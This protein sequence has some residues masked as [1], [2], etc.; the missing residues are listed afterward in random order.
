MVDESEA[1]ILLDHHAARLEGKRRIK[2]RLSVD[3]SAARALLAPRAPVSQASKTFLVERIG[4]QRS[5]LYQHNHRRCE[6]YGSAR[7]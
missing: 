6:G 1:M 2:L 4:D 3:N 5:P 7:V